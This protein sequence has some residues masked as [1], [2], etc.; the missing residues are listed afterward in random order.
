[1][2]YKQAL[3]YINGTSWQSTKPG[4]ERVSALLEKLGNPQASLQ[5]VHVAGTNG[6]GSICA[7]LASV[8][9]KSGLK[10]GLFTSP[11][12]SRFT[13]RMRI[14]GKEISELRVAEL[15][16][17][18]QPLA[19]A[20]EDHP[21]EFE[22]MTAAALLWFYREKC[23]IVVLEVGLGG[24]FDA[25]NVIPRPLCSVISNIGLDH[26]AI[27]G[28]SLEQIAF[29]KAGIIKENSCA[30]L[31]QQGFEVMNVIRDICDMRNAELTVPDFD[32]AELQ[33]DSL[34][35]QVFSY[36]GEAY[37]IP[38]LGEHQIYNAVCVIECVN[39]LRRQ[40]IDIE[41]SALEA[42]LYAVSW[43]ARFEVLHDDP[44]FLLDGGHNPQCAF[45]LAEGLR[46]YFPD[47]RRVLLLG[48][49]RDKDCKAVADILSPLFGE[50]VTVTPPS[51][52]A[53]SAR[54]LGELLSAYG[55][56]VTVC[57]SIEEGVQT[58]LDIA[59][60]SGGMVCA[61]GSLYSCGRI[62]E[63]FYLK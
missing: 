62:R 15:I 50:F 41:P 29:E 5:F 16:E 54:E 45:A 40:G 9:K 30:V 1:M 53:L 35:G 22:M 48:M 4:L 20:M 39:V 52:R 24:R 25:T 31:Y 56:P 58:A 43:P 14:N 27:L 26:T 36:R 19:D 8:L 42:G 55:K 37:A 3:D 6:K 47:S 33:F 46:R 10:T 7:M 44:V 34:E 2:D 11:Y 21:T 63:F 23:D 60:E 17:E 57:E 28:N 18:I 12:L 13:E 61:A 59:R 49:L 38:L 51:G 32:D